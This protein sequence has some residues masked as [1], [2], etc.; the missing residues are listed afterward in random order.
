[1]AS[2]GD[3][4]LVI[5]TDHHLF[6]SEDEGRSW[7]AVLSPWK[8]RAVA[9]AL[10]SRVSSGNEAPALKMSFRA[11]AATAATLSGT[12]TDPTGAVI[13]GAT[14]VATNPAA[15]VVRSAA[16][17]NRG[18]FRMEGL[19]PGSYRIEAQATGFETESFS[20]EVSPAQQAVADVRL[21]VGSASQTVA[22]D[23]AA[24][25]LE[26]LPTTANF[27]SRYEL[28][29]EDGEHWISTDGQTWTRK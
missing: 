21:R 28:T 12:I 14:V 22:V 29:T 8:G 15:G 18:Q 17:D 23:A 25:P 2:H 10:A 26:T 13:P 27:L 7:K 11:A 4:R 16:T 1:M 9:I 5:D 19:V 20:A 6:L 3:Q 24:V